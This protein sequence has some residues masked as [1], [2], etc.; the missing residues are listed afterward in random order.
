[1]NQLSKNF[2]NQIHCCDAIVGIKRL[3][4]ECIPLTVTSPPYDGLRDFGGHEFT[5]DLFRGIAQELWRVT[6][7]GGVV[8]WVVA[9]QIDGGYSGTSFRQALCFMELGF[10][11]H[12]ILIMTRLGGCYVGPR[13][14]KI[15]FGFVFSKGTPRSMNLIREK[16]NKHAG[17]MCRFRARR[18]DGILRISQI[19]K[20]VAEKGLIGPIWDYS[21][22]YTTTTPDRYV[23]DLH[24]AVMP[25]KMTSDLITSWSNPAELVFD[26]LAGSGTT[27]KMAVLNNRRY[28][29][30]EIHQPY[31]E[32][33]RRRLCD[34]REEYR[35]RV[36]AWLLGA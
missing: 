10:R 13:Y 21:A 31:I 4:D 3:P 26:P 18:N 25:D 24:P 28:L 17:K 35:R 23:H 12:D 9:D 15:E 5:D 14:G 33:A 1:M 11:L 8:A 16:P 2:V 27:P 34:A 19:A 29:A 20:P 7:T 6:C 22:G 32:L 30:F 36:D